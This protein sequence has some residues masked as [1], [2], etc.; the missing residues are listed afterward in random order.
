M[1]WE[2]NV[3]IKKSREKLLVVFKWLY[4]NLGIKRYFFLAVLGMFFFALG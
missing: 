3:V 2:E 1:D 4:P